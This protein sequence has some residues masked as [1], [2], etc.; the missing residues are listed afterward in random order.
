MLQKQNHIVYSI[1]EGK[2]I[3]DKVTIL[4][5]SNKDIEGIDLEVLMFDNL[6]ELILDGNSK[7][8]KLPEELEYLPKLERIS[9]RKCHHML[10]G[11]LTVIPN[12][13]V[14]NCSEMDF[15]DD[16]NLK[17]IQFSE[18]LRHLIMINCTNAFSKYTVGQGLAHFWALPAE[19]GKLTNLES[20]ILDNNKIEKLPDS[21]QFL[22]K[23]KLLSVKNNILESLPECIF[24]L[25]ELSE[26]YVKGN[27]LKGQNSSFRKMLSARPVFKTDFIISGKKDKKETVSKDSNEAV[28]SEKVLKELER[29][30]ID[31]VDTCNKE[32]YFTLE[33]KEEEEVCIPVEVVQLLWGYK[34]VGI[35]LEW[36]ESSN[37][38]VDE[39]YDDEEYRDEKEDEEEFEGED[40]SVVIS[41]GFYLDGSFIIGKD[42][43]IAIG[44][45]EVSGQE[46]RISICLNDENMSDPM[47]Y[48]DDYESVPYEFDSLSSFLNAL[49][50]K[51]V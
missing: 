10:L 23:L 17:K 9:L 47:I 5:L 41:Y 8:L 7:L 28:F 20:L 25:P 18:K 48:L 11:Q 31:K 1:K 4:D 14:L 6:E 33:D 15:P 40:R 39:T 16:E 37:Y 43:Y 29:L 49:I 42:V 3:P 51:A 45:C 13:K 19:I 34:W 38:D 32:K 35:D 44:G 12:L 36:R 27:N 50:I 2:E 30:G 46:G 26:L 21:F 22:T 24:N